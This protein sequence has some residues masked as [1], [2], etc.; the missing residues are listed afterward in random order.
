MHATQPS[1]PAPGKQ[2]VRVPI[3]D[4][5]PAP[6]PSA[7]LSRKHRARWAETRVPEESGWNFCFY[8]HLKLDTKCQQGLK[9]GACFHFPT[10]RAVLRHSPPRGPR[11]RTLSG[12]EGQAEPGPGRPWGQGAGAAVR[13]GTAVWLGEPTETSGQDLGPPRPAEAGRELTGE[14]MAASVPPVGHRDKELAS[15]CCPPQ[16]A[17]TP[18]R[19]WFSE[20]QR[21]A[22]RAHPP[23]EGAAGA[24]RAAGAQVPEKNI[25]NRTAGPQEMFER[26]RT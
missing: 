9:D 21:P 18:A 2:L 7:R 19:L 22:P 26:R 20:H 23:Q 13:L 3:T 14:A 16:A 11:S 1:G 10:N 12:E 25:G 15:G 17:E 5:A 24:G 4:I 6:S 8:F